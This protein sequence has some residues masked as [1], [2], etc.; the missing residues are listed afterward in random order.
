MVLHPEKRAEAEAIFRKWG[1]DFAIIGKTTDDLRFVVKHQGVVKA[2]LPIKEL[3]DEAPL[4]D[5]PHVA[6]EK[7]PILDAA[8]DRPADRQ[9]RG[10]EALRQRPISAPSAGSGSN[11]T[12]SSWAI[13]AG[14]RRRCGGDPASARAAGLAL[15]TDVTPRYCAADPYR[16]RQAGGGR[17]LAQS[18]RRRRACRCAVTDNLNFGNPEKPEIMGQIVGCHRRHG[19]GLPRARFPGRIGQC[20]AL[21]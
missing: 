21:Q 14:T 17:S 12:G 7:L 2:D 10:L 1:L 3:G 13:R 11:M 16:G 15:T 19:R 5:R 18:L 8:V 9:W 6:P 20:L 4:Y